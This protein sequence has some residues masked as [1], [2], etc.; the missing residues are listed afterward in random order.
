MTDAL[1]MAKDYIEIKTKSGQKIKLEETIDH[2]SA[3]EHLTDNLIMS[4]RFSD[5]LNLQRSRKLLQRIDKREIYRQLVNVSY[6]YKPQLDVILQDFKHS[7][8]IS[9][10]YQTIDYGKKSAN[11]VESYGFYLKSKQE[12]ISLK[13]EDVSELL[14]ENFCEKRIR[15]FSKTADVEESNKLSEELTKI[16]KESNIN[17]K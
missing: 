6:D 8:K 1:F 11:P 12:M 2:M 16:L 7:D 10:N 14:P 15:V 4:I 3:F 5:D 17:F 9:I 13:R